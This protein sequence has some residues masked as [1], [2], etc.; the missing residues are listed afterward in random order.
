MTQL[1]VLANAIEKLEAAETA[2]GDARDAFDPDGKDYDTITNQFEVVSDAIHIIQNILSRIEQEK[3]LTV[4][5]PPVMQTMED[6]HDTSV[7]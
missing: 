3:Y 2:L 4:L 5:L 1:S 7:S 6:N